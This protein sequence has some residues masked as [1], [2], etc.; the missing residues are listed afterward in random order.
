MAEASVESDDI[1]V[2]N[3]NDNKDTTEDK[4]TE[5]ASQNNELSKSENEQNDKGRELVSY[6]CYQER[7]FTN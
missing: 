3:E 1:V 5:N 4:E 2:K 6:S 7:L